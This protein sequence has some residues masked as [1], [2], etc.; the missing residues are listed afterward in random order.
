MFGAAWATVAAYALRFIPVYLF[1]Q[2]RYRVDYSW[3]K[4]V[5]LS[6]ILA[7][8][9]VFRH[10][11]DRLSIPMSLLGSTAVLAVT[12]AIIYGRLLDAREREFIRA[13]VRRPFAQ[14]TVPAIQDVT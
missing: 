13:L 14:R 5:E 12:T 10:F 6:L 9:V 11:A 3:S 7:A 1:A 4:V 8:A 2:A